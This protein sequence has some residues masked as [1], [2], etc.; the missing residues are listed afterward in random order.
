MVV[1]CMRRVW[2]SLKEVWS[3][4]EFECSWCPV[5]RLSTNVNEY[6]NCKFKLILY[7]RVAYDT[8]NRLVVP[9]N[10]NRVEALRDR[11]CVVQGQLVVP[12]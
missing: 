12:V 4:L 3:P 6:V 1:P 2:F 5:L 9:V 8:Y 7:V 10:Y 11:N